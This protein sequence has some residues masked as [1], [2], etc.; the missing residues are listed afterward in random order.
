MSA[1][2]AL[3]VALAIAA[4]LAHAHLDARDAASQALCGDHAPAGDGAPGSGAC[5]LCLA[6]G[7]APAA[8]AFCASAPPAPADPAAAALAPRAPLA[9]SGARGDPADPRAPPSL[10][11]I[12]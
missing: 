2:I 12:H 8:L 6:T 7:H 3:A 1:G 5:A 10:S 11:L 9:R 4:P